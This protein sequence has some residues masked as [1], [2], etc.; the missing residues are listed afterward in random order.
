L[1][2]LRCG[3]YDNVIRLLLPLVISDQELT[4][5][6]DILEEAFAVVEGGRA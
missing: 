5:G 4:R 2:I 6:L 3:V 1:L